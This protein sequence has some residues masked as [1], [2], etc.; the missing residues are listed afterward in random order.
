[1]GTPNVVGDAVLVQS[2]T[3]GT[4][5][6]QLGPALDGHFSLAAAG[7]LNGGRVSYTVVDSLTAPTLRE[8]VEG[9]YTAGS[10]GTLTRA[11]VKRSSTGAAI[12][13]GVGTR[14]IFLTPNSGN[15]A[16]LDTDGLLP[17]S[18]IPLRAALQA[19]PSGFDFELGT[20]PTAFV[21]IGV[22]SKARLLETEVI[23]RVESTNAT[24]CT[25]ILTA[26]VRNAADT[27]T[28][29][30]LF[31]G[32]ATVSSGTSRFVTFPGSAEYAFSSDPAGKFVR[33]F[34]RI[35]ASISG[36]RLKE[37]RPKLRAY[38]EG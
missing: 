36:V 22:P 10:P 14:Y 20:A 27:V 2:T 31:L 17:A 6:Y 30:T 23:A 34:A 12:N 5:T 29:Q 33:F 7:I 18:A 3:T 9:I 28:E 21:V 24:A 38:L 11:S 37:L 13:W 26:D 19:A 8:V 16:L 35:D 15:L 32:A 25:V 1:M 4:G